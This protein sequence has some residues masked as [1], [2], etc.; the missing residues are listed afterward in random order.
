MG[1]GLSAG[2]AYPINAGTPTGA[3]ATIEDTSAVSA[4]TTVSLRVSSISA[5]SGV[6]VNID[7][8]TGEDGNGGNDYDMSA[9]VI[10]FF[11]SGTDTRVRQEYYYS[12]PAALVMDGALNGFSATIGKNGSLTSTTNQTG[13]TVALDVKTAS[14]TAGD[15]LQFVL[16]WGT[17]F[18]SGTSFDFI[19]NADTF[20]TITTISSANRLYK[21]PT[22]WGESAISANASL[23]GPAG[24]QITAVNTRISD[25]TIDIAGKTNHAIFR[26]DVTLASAEC[27]NTAPVDW[28]AMGLA[29]ATLDFSTC[30]ISLA[31][32]NTESAVTKAYT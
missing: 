13:V 1:S 3:T 28:V 30:T 2:D 6:A 12:S 31:D 8:S 4:G 23:T 25:Y 18:G 14:Q 26:L 11:F 9:T 24:I 27:T 15:F 29:S 17:Q 22:A 32:T 10:G 20:G 7:F 21:F 19:S 16:P 5:A